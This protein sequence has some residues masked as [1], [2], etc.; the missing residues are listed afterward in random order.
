M[1]TA[2][3]T[4]QTRVRG[5][6]T[7]GGILFARKITANVFDEGE[8][9]GGGKRDPRTLTQKESPEIILLRLPQILLLPLLLLLLLLLFTFLTLL[10]FCWYQKKV[11]AH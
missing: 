11:L 10:A 7:F 8:I 5:F 1:F 2:R 6:E 9:E 3:L 4:E